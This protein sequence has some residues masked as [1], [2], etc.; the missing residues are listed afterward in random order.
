M[1][2]PYKLYQGTSGKKELDLRNELHRLLYGASDE[3]SKGKIGL[4]RRMR[5]DENGE[6]IKCPC[7]NTITNEPSRDF[8]CRYCHGHGYFW[9]ELK[10]V[11]YRDDD[12]F[13]KKEGNTEEFERDY[14]YFEY[15]VDIRTSDFIIEVRLDKEG[16]P[17]Q[18]VE[19]EKVFNILSADTFRSDNGRVEFWQIRAKEEQKWSVWY[20]VK[21]RQYN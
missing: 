7:R 10:I 3:I 21:N 1:S 11:Y 9:D 5:A 6:L 18:P 16:R 14:F 13:T 4:L 8:F 17:Y 20:G 2:N 19:R 15:N 12:S